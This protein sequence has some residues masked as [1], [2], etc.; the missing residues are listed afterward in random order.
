MEKAMGILLMVT[1][2]ICGTGATALAW[3]CPALQMDKP[4]A[5]LA[6]I[7]GVGFALIQGFR[8]RH[9]AHDGGAAVSVEIANKE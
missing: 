8:F 2:G 6:G 5:T 4:E 1:L 3:L 9:F 7:I